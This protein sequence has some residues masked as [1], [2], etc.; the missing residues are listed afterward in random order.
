[1]SRAINL[2][3]HEA[4]V[5]ARC[6]ESGLS[7][8]AIERLPSG[9]TRLVCMTSAG[10]DQIRLRLGNHVIEATMRRFPFHRRQEGPRT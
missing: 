8:S 9:G 1:M 2:A 10:A 6:A 3:M 7:I 4:G 5:K